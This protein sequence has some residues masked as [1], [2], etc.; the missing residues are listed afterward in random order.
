MTDMKKILSIIVPMYKTEMYVRECLTSILRQDLPSSRYEVIAVDNGSPDCCAD[1][2]RTLQTEYSNLKLVTLKDNRLPS[3]ARNAG[4]DVAVGKYLMFVDSDDYLEQNVLCALVCAIDSE[5]LDIVHFGCEQL[6]EGSVHKLPTIKETS[7]MDGA[8][9]YFE[10]MHKEDRLCVSWSKIYRRSF[11]DENNI[12]C[13]EGLL[14]EDEEF[15]Y[16]VFAAAQRVKHLKF[17]PYVYRCNNQSATQNRLTVSAAQSD[18]VEIGVMYDD[19]K[20][21][22]QKGYDSRFVVEME[23]IIRYNIRNTLESIHLYSMEQ[24]R[25]IR[26][27]MHQYITLRMLPYMSRKKFILFKLR[28]I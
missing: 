28:F 14:Y 18:M 2:V 4:L 8:T 16:K 6:S 3:G 13:S 5:N 22:K 19:I 10:N 20:R 23:K 1:I 25:Q 24:Q 15:S 12:R 21:F 26:P 7:I 17:C 9:F 27:Y 11:L